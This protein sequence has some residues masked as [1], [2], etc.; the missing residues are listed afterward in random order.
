MVL[1]KHNIKKFNLK[2]Y[3]LMTREVQTELSKAKEEDFSR[4]LSDLIHYF[5]LVECLYVLG[6]NGLQVSDTVFGDLE[7][8]RKN[9]FIFRPAPL[10]VDHTMKDYYYMMMDAVLRKATY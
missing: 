8:N 2:K 9:R 5:P 7:G 6:E 10:G 1:Q 3:E 4:K